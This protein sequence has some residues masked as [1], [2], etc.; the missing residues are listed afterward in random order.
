VTL[1]EAY[2]ALGLKPALT[3]EAE[4]L[5]RGGGSVRRVGTTTRMLVM[6]ALDLC[7]GIP[8]ALVAFDRKS[9]NDARSTAMRYART[10]GA[11]DD[12]VDQVVT[13]L[14]TS[15][16]PSDRPRG[17][18]VYVDHCRDPLDGDDR[19]VLGPLGWAYSARLVR[20]DPVVHDVYAVHDRDDVL[21]GHVTGDGL[22]SLRARHFVR[23][24]T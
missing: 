10:L 15:A 14:S 3:F 16:V 7:D 1:D 20:R 23:L 22:R 12:H 6:A 4:Q 11:A 9:V 21:I 13:W 2:E 24:V 18:R 17:E 8:V 5:A 19:R